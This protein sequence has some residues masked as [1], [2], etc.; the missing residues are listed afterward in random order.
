M[1]SFAKRTPT[2]PKPQPTMSKLYT[3]E[4]AKDPSKMESR[5]KIANSINSDSCPKVIHY[6]GG[7]SRETPFENHFDKTRNT[8]FRYERDETDIPKHYI[9][10]EW[11]GEKLWPRMKQHF[12]YFINSDF[13]EAYFD[14]RP[15]AKKL[16]NYFWLDFCGMPTEELLDCIYYSFLDK[17]NDSPEVQDIYLTFYLNGRGIKFVS[18]LLNRYGKS[19]QDRAQSLCDSIKEKFDNENFSYSVFDAYQNGISPMGVIKISRK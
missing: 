17:E 18:N 14:I 13:F 19:I 6:L 1:G 5:T 4:V 11:F 10:A 16:K 2:K 12:G 15:L 3:A 7:Q 8:F 9:Q